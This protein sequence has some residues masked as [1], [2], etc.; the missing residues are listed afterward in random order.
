MAVGLGLGTPLPKYVIDARNLKCND[1]R[2][3]IA[4][5]IIHLL[6]TTHANVAG[7]YFLMAEIQ[8]KLPFLE[9]FNAVN[10]HAPQIIH[11][12]ESLH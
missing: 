2:V 12:A 10:A 5:G 6:L 8:L 9:L 1:K 3:T 11:A 4:K 7:I